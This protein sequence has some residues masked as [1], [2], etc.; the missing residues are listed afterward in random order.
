MIENTLLNFIDTLDAS[1]KKIP[2][3]TGNSLNITSSQAQY[4]EA[5]HKLG[6]PTLSELA[7]GLDITKASVTVAVNKLL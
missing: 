7:D 1:F 3:S 2:E 6:E 5:I 4:I